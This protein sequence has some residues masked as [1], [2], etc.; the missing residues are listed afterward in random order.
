MKQ[1]NM[2]V[3]KTVSTRRKISR[4]NW[5][6]VLKGYSYGCAFCC[7]AMGAVSTSSASST[8]LMVSMVALVIMGALT[9]PS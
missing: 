9:R 5:L 8:L 2:P 4:I 1:N 3:L 7:A 6:A